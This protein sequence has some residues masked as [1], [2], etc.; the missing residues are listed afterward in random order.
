MR[1]ET[2]KTQMHSETNAPTMVQSILKKQHRKALRIRAHRI[3]VCEDHAYFA[4]Q[5]A[6]IFLG[7]CENPNNYLGTLA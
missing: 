2:D 7:R 4:V 1:Q 3:P 6:H 5:C